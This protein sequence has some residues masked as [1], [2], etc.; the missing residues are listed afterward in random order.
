VIKNNKGLK[1]WEDKSKS[2]KQRLKERKWNNSK[3]YPTI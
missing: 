3:N 1:L 2:N